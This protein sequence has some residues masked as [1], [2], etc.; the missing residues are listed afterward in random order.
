MSVR[1]KGS[2]SRIFKKDKEKH[3]DAAFVISEP[4]NFREGVHVT[5]DQSS[6]GFK[7]ILTL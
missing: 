6:Q 4:K 5:F 7:V 3:Q 2:L 1:R